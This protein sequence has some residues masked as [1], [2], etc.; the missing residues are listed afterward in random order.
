M[1]CRIFALLA[2]FFMHSMSAQEVTS[3]Y[4]LL[5]SEGQKISFDGLV[6][7]ALD[8]D[9]VF[10]GEYHDQSIAH[11]LQLKLLEEL[12]RAKPGNIILGMEMFETDVQVIL[13]EYLSDIITQKKFEQ[14]AR[15]WNNYSSDYKPMVEF[16]KNH[17]IPVVATNVPGRYANAVYHRGPEVLQS[18]SM[19]AQKFLPPFPIHFN[20]EIPCYQKMIETMGGHGGSNIAYAQALRDASM[21]YQIGR[22][23]Q[24]GNTLLHING[25]Y[26]SDYEEGILY[27]LKRIHPQLKTLVITTVYSDNHETLQEENL[28]KGD[29]YLSIHSSLIPNK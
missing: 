2:I 5:G 18:L 15:I 27:Y 13:D 8:A 7:S 9:I 20:M 23:F 4:I 6:R 24:Q 21:A 16:C 14:E 10:F 22:V 26:H 28:G 1:V 17:Q 11:D 3:K 25:S 29:I 12:H 19:E